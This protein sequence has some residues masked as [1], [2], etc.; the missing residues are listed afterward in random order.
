[1]GW[2]GCVR[3][4]NKLNSY[5]GHLWNRE[6]TIWLSMLEKQPYGRETTMLIM[7]KDGIIYI[8]CVLIFCLFIVSCCLWITFLHLCFFVTEVF[9]MFFQSLLCMFNLIC[10][11]FSIFMGSCMRLY[12]IFCIY[13]HLICVNMFCR[14]HNCNYLKVWKFHY[15][16]WS[17]W[18][19]NSE[20]YCP[21]LCWSP[22]REV[23]QLRD[24]GAEKGVHFL[25][26]CMLRGMRFCWL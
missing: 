21:N 7:L 1:L 8:Q 3:K 17:S 23:V 24:R 11:M 10:I 5:H 20:T 18:S 22:G 14:N 25:G 4:D 9:C 13:L 12:V 2:W 15:H 16:S 6:T 19:H 26:L